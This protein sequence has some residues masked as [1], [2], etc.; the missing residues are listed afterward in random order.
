[1]GRRATGPFEAKLSPNQ[2]ISRMRPRYSTWSDS[3]LSGDL[4]GITGTM[5]IEIVREAL[6]YSGLRPYG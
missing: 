4:E 5:S 6:V 3:G 1:V 2:V